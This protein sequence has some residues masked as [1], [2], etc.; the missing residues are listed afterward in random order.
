MLEPWNYKAQRQKQ[1][2]KE[3]WHAYFVTVANHN[4]IKCQLS[5]GADYEK[6]EL[7]A[8]KW[9]DYFLKLSKS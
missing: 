1:R 2:K 5:Y 7:W 3:Q 4:P 9:W 8:T 6:D